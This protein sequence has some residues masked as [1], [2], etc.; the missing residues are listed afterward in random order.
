MTVASGIA[1]WTMVAPV[2]SSAP[3]I[4]TVNGMAPKRSSCPERRTVSTIRWLSTNVP[5]ALP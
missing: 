4:S 2:S 5:F 1:L 3:V